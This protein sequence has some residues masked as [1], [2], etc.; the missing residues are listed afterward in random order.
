MCNFSEKKRYPNES[1]HHALSVQYTPMLEYSTYCT[2]PP[3]TGP[4]RWDFPRAL[5][6]WIPKISSKMSTSENRRKFATHVDTF[7]QHLIHPSRRHHHKSN[8]TAPFSAARRSRA[9]APRPPYTHHPHQTLSTRRCPPAF[10]V[11]EVPIGL[12]V[13]YKTLVKR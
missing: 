10:G 3:P 4:L 12:L 1:L 6:L 9:I 13:F 8:I 2:L 5:K 7:Q 11:S